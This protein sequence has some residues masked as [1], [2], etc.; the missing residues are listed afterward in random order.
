MRHTR[1]D[2]SSSARL[3]HGRRKQTEDERKGSAAGSTCARQGCHSGARVD[4]YD[5]PVIC[6]N[7]NGLPRRT[8]EAWPAGACSISM[9]LGDGA[10][11]SK[12]ACM[13]LLV[14]GGR[15]ALCDVCERTFGR[16]RRAE[17]GVPSKSFGP[18]K[19]ELSLCLGRLCHVDLTWPSPL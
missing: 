10:R 14:D 7:L 16:R 12:G 13:A 5:E 18:R 17:E 6:G 8:S 2:G 19:T 15:R 9:E 1:S 11:V 3:Q 4:A